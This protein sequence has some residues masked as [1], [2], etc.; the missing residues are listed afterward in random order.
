MARVTRTLRMLGRVEF[1]LQPKFDGEH[2]G[3]V[4]T[5]P[6]G[7]RLMDDQLTYG[8]LA[9][10]HVGILP[11]SDH[12]MTELPAPLLE[13]VPQLLQLSLQDIEPIGKPSDMFCLQMGQ[14][15][16]IMRFDDPAD[17]DKATEIL[18]DLWDNL[19]RTPALA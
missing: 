16:M 11:F 19:Q 13:A 14:D 1:Q 7:V 12:Q 15:W 3:F 17:A 10:G 2:P 18:R 4:P 9:R 8:S 5:P 6:V